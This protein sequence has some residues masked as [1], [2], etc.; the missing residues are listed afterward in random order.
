MTSQ[1]CS[2]LDVLFGDREDAADHVRDV[3]GRMEPPPAVR[4]LSPDTCASVVGQLAALVTDMLLDLDLGG[5]AQLGWRKHGAVVSAMERTSVAPHS[6]E[7]VELWNQR[8]TSVHR[9]AFDIIVDGLQVHTLRVDIE[10]VI[11]V[12]VMS[13]IVRAGSLVGL[14]AGDCVV[15]ATLNGYGF[16]MSRERR[17]DL[18]FTME[19]R[20]ISRNGH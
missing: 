15:R 16:E 4:R 6:H 10:I 9:P 11:D 5:V 20:S 18:G 14:R 8:L 7:I 3:F 12:K 17:I 13:A 19:A 1:E 2:L